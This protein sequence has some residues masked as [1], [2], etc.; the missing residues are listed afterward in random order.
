MVSERGRARLCA[1]VLACASLGWA[2]VAGA[3]PGAPEKAEA[4]A[5]MTEGRTFR[6]Q[7][8]FEAALRA[9]NTADK[10]MHVPT[11]GLE[12]AR[13]LEA[14]GRLVEARSALKRVL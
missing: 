8:N 11:T 2:R 14:M 3:E 13:T 12:V 4:R 1:A 5:A 7:R 10:I 6:S 9:F